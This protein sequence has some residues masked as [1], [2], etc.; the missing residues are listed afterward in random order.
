MNKVIAIN[1]GG[2][3]YQL[4]EAG[5]EA[6]RAYLDQ[7]SQRL[8]DDPG[9]A[10]IIADLEQ[11]IAEKCDKVLNPN[12]SVV[13][14][15]EVARIIQE[16][17]PVEGQDKAENV[18]AKNEYIGPR[19]PRRFFLIREDAVLAGVCTGLA[20]YF[21][22]DVTLVRLLFIL[23]TVLTG[24]IWVLLYLALAILVPYADTAETRAQARGE[25]FNAEALVQRAKER[26]SEGYER[27][28]GSK[29]DWNDMNTAHENHRK[30]KQMRKMQKWQWKQ[31]WKRERSHWNPAYG[32][33]RAIL[34]LVWIGALISLITK[35]AIFGIAVTIIPIWLA[36]FLLFIVFFM[37]TGPM[38]AAHS[39]GR[40]DPTGVYHYQYEYRSDPFDGFVGVITAIFLIVAFLWAY[41]DVP[42]FYFFLHHPIAGTKELFAYV[43]SLWQR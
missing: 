20:A 42:Q 38:Q 12:K 11:A 1:L 14:T 23:L 3:A 2:R 39:Y 19:A 41:H 6:L 18:G 32:L 17:G 40:Y 35:G 15:N 7:A 33:V 36:V 29:F 27:V 26:W 30:W 21:D 31:E 22:I 4:E 9:K 37:I 5:Y 16:M 10:E 8:A 24:G 28:T 13:L 34:A 25:A 43:G